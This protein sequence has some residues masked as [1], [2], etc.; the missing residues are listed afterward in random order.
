MTSASET[1]FGEVRPVA[2]ISCDIVGHSK[3]DDLTLQLERVA[4]IN[5]IV[6]RTI[7]Q[8]DPAD[9]V[10]ASGGDGG[11]VVFRG[12]GWCGPAI[13]LL[14][15]LRAW[16][17]RSGTPLR[18]TAHVGEVADVRGA[19]GRVQIVGDGINRAGW[20]LTRGSRHGVVVTGEFQDAVEA[21]GADP[22]LTFHDRR[23]LRDK[24]RRHVV[25]R[26]MS[27][28]EDASLWDLPVEEELA[29]LERAQE[30]GRGWEVLYHAKRILQVN[31]HDPRAMAALR[32][33]KTRS[34]T[35]SRLPAEDDNDLFFE[36]LG[37]HVLP[38]IVQLGQL[39]ERRY[40]EV[41][42]RFGDRGNT[43]FAILRGQIGVYKS[44]GEG[45][46]SPA[47][48][49]HVHQEGEVVGEL[50]FA[51][52][53][54]R[55]ADLVALSD[56]ALLS[57]NHND[58]VSRLP[59]NGQGADARD[60]L[61]SFITYRVLEHVSQH[62][63]YLVGQDRAGPLTKGA[64]KWK[65]AL[66][67]LS[68]QCELVTVPDGGSLHLTVESVQSARHK[69]GSVADGIY[70]LASGA[71]S[72]ASAP[73][74]VLTGAQFPILWAQLPEIMVLPCQTFN[75]ID[76][77]TKVLFVSAAALRELEV[78]KRDAFQH[79]L[80][81]AA[82]QCFDHDVFVAYNSVDTP[83][84]ERWCSALR[85]HGLAVFMDYPTHGKEFPPALLT[86]IRRSRAIVPLISANVNLRDPAD[87]WVRK[88][89]DAHRHYFDER[90]IF[91]VALPG[92][93]PREIAPGFPPIVVGHDE[94]AAIE[95]LVAE[96]TALRDG[97]K[98]PP[99]SLTR[100][101]DAWGT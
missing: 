22:G 21:V 100:K 99:Y 98:D 70:I 78:R 87:N 77:E 65:D 92:G 46:D 47:E 48:P 14:A 38:V 41:I 62:V 91:P 60:R 24:N 8:G 2:I 9:V 36:R 84:A 101:S 17:L 53:R 74:R 69:G 79:A 12:A 40:N 75:I 6:A 32:D 5:G 88:E 64:Q 83:A 55:T 30:Q 27:T 67:T 49:A 7:A 58:L 80:R 18:V 68:G 59:N 94:D 66:R 19:D 37:S 61:D 76:D 10:W 57:F 85:A 13:A 45:S 39:V 52:S 33:L 73:H 3:I 28:A 51:L 54:N 4:A 42:C 50:A 72:S 97:R 63:P 20:L 26:L 16:S 29:K 89:L 31:Q 1:P 82:A 44:E 71:V 86:A 93:R 81:R 95:K 96:L 23:L 15:G 43:M 56:T 34:L 25:L 35:N 90:R 11:H